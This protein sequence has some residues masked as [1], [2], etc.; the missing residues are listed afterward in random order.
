LNSIFPV[1]ELTPNLTTDCCTFVETV[2]LDLLVLV[3]TSKF[4]S[5]LHQEKQKPQL[6]QQTI[7]DDTSSLQST[8]VASFS[9][10]Y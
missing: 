2:V 8:K 9:P 5:A 10:I 6:F 7:R 1:S 4:A 3:N